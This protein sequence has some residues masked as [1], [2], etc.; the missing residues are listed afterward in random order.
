MGNNHIQKLL[1]ALAFALLTPAIGYLVGVMW[2]AGVAKA[3]GLPPSLRNRRLWAT[4]CLAA[5][6]FLVASIAWVGYDDFRLWWLDSP[7]V[8]LVVAVLVFVLV[9]ALVVTLIVR[10]WRGNHNACREPEGPDP[11]ILL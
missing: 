6:L 2:S 9:P 5:V 8:L 4:F 7:L 11:S 3:L 1:I 10:L